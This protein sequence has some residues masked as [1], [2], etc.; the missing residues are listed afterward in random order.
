[1]SSNG[2]TPKISVADTLLA[3][4]FQKEMTKFRILTP[5]G[6][7]AEGEWETLA[8]IPARLPDR[9]MHYFDTEDADVV[10]IGENGKESRLGVLGLVR[11][12]IR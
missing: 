10:V 3:A 8:E 7:Q 9:F 5:S 11:G 12:V 1:M 6:V 2:R 4:S